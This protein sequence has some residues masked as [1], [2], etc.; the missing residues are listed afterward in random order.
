MAPAQLGRLATP[1]GLLALVAALTATAWAWF[2]P[3]VVLAAAVIVAAIAFAAYN[4][5]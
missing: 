5:G 1:G 4:N 3:T 2:V